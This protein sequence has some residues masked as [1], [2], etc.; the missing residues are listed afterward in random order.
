MT[1]EDLIKAFTMKAN[2]Y[3]TETIAEALGVTA[4][5]LN[6]ALHNVITSKNTKQSVYPKLNEYMLVNGYTSTD[7]SKLL[8]ENVRTF[9]DFLKGKT[10]SYEMIV[11]VIKLTGFT[12][13]EIFMSD[14]ESVKQ[15]IESEVQEND[16]K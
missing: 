5:A 4:G 8:G 10:K 13:E 12:F 6:T 2:G 3:K 1:K 11:K 9:A 15:R 14:K 7:M 16:S